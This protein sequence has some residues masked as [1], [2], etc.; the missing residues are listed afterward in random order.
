M[1]EWILLQH[2]P[3]VIAAI[4]QEQRQVGQSVLEAHF[5]ARR[6]DLQRP[7]AVVHHTGHVWPPDL[8]QFG[9]PS[10]Q[11]NLQG[12]HATKVTRRGLPENLARLRRKSGFIASSGRFRPDGSRARNVITAKF[13]WCNRRTRRRKRRARNLL[14]AVK[15]NAACALAGILGIHGAKALQLC[16]QL[17]LEALALTAHDLRQALNVLHRRVV[18]P[19]KV[20]DGRHEVPE[21]YRPRFALLAIFFKDDVHKVDE[22]DRVHAH[23]IKRQ[24]CLAA[25]QNRGELR[26]ADMAVVVFIDPIDDPPQPVV[27]GGHHDLLFLRRGHRAHN[28][29]QDPN[30][31]IHDHEVGEGDEDE[32]RNG[33]DDAFLADGFHDKGQVVQ[34]RP[35]DDK[36]Q[37]RSGD[38][39]EEIKRTPAICILRGQLR[40]QDREHVHQYEQ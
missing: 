33:A 40:Q 31:H 36:C 4:V 5:H 1:H 27:H 34:K 14:G 21:G 15:L 30:E 17:F 10:I 22:P 16:V 25:L 23:V 2:H 28:F 8:P 12:R 11:E 24:H 32:K 20:E 7:I 26:L 18:V 35:G 6:P 37:H 29:A 19:S 39:I 3:A 38:A 9:Q 13:R